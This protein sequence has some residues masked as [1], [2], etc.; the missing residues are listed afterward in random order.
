[1]IVSPLLSHLHGCTHCIE[2]ARR[3]EPTNQNSPQV[4]TPKINFT[5]PPHLHYPHIDTFP[6]TL[7][8]SIS[9]ISSP[10]L[11]RLLSTIQLTQLSYSLGSKSQWYALHAPG[12]LVSPFEAHDLS[13]HTFTCTNPS[14]THLQGSRSRSTKSRAHR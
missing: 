6:S 1:M 11:F 8:S 14:L 10:P 5:Y 4:S 12:L 3:T 7:S 13:C 2:K 9:S